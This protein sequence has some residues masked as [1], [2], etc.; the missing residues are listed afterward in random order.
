MGRMKE[1]SNYL[2]HEIL[3]WTPAVREGRYI[4]LY[5]LDGQLLTSSSGGFADES[6]ALRAGRAAAIEHVELLVLDV[7]KR[8]LLLH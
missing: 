1:R 8:Q 5:T 6:S 3:V 4:W 7:R 2:G